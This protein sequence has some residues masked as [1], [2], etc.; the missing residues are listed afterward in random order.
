[1][2][3]LDIIEFKNNP[4]NIG[5]DEV[6][7]LDNLLKDYPYFST[8]QLLLAKGLHNVESIRYNREL[9]KT[10]AY[11][12]DRKLLFQLITKNITKSRIV[13]NEEMS[14]KTTEEKLEI[15]KPLNFTI[16]E[17]HSFSEWLNLCRIKKINRQES[18][19]NEKIVDDFL[20]N[21]AG[22]SRPKK[23]TFFSPS[24]TARESLV[25]NEEI[26][27]ETLAK[28]YIEQGH[29]DKAISAYKKLSLKF[30]QKSSLFAAQ[31]KLINELKEK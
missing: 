24:K 23:A 16:E 11:C 10:A 18:T 9:R 8:A 15:G 27:T 21:K 1:M 14:S 25:E 19:N 7:L 4:Q 29:F 28:V 26:V 20:T 31:I 3:I 30:P 12:G 5:E 6:D 13:P 17:E 22:I 2:V